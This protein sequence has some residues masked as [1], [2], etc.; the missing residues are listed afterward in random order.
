MPKAIGQ[1][2]RKPLD[3]LSELLKATTN[4]ELL[5]LIVRAMG[6]GVDRLGNYATEEGAEPPPIDVVN[7]GIVFGHRLCELL[8][9]L[10]KSSRVRQ[11]RSRAQDC[12]TWLNDDLDALCG[13][14]KVGA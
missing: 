4:D 6:V 2:P 11:L 12:Q 7:E 5:E 3:Q 10:A 13:A 14:A 8:P 1:T 9:I